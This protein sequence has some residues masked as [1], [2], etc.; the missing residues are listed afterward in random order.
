[1]QIIGSLVYFGVFRPPFEWAFSFTCWS[2]VFQSSSILYTTKGF[3][4][5]STGFTIVVYVFELV[6]ALLVLNWQFNLE[7]IKRDLFVHVR[8][9]QN[10]LDF[11]RTTQALRANIAQE[12]GRARAERLITAFLCHE[13]RNPMNGILGYAE[14][15]SDQ[16]AWVS[17]ET[18]AGLATTILSCSRHV[19]NILDHV[20]D[21]SKLE[22]GKLCMERD[23]IVCTDLCAELQSSMGS[24]AAAGVE[25]VCEA[26][27]GLMFVGD[28]IRWMQVLMNLAGN[29]L[30]FTTQAGGFVK[31]FI[32]KTQAG[33]ILCE[34]LDSAAIIPLDVQQRLFNKYE[35]AKNLQVGTGLGLVIA[36]NIVRMM[37]SEVCAPFSPH[38][39]F[40][41]V[42]TRSRS[43]FS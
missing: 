12:Q 6:A 20:L 32:R 21:I 13:I 37:K 2:F 26:E 43:F 25:F 14:Q 42:R 39:P 35:Q 23:T 30:K 36:Q 10:S 34:I 18:T 33:N 28:R 17:P 40:D 16:A 5:V 38:P 11:E 41:C 24:R 1:M 27:A 7:E 22:A 19:L 29:A 4:S 31:V 3:T 9:L 15:L 8:G